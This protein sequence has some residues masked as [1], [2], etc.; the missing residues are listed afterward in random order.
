MSPRTHHILFVTKSLEPSNHFS[1]ITQ[2][3]G[4]LCCSLL[5]GKLLY[6]LITALCQQIILWLTS[7]ISTVTDHK[8][9]IWK[10][11]KLTSSYYLYSP[12]QSSA[13]DSLSTVKQSN[14]QI[15]LA[16][17]EVFVSHSAQLCQKS[18]FT[19]EAIDYWRPMG[20]Q[21]YITTLRCLVVQSESKS[22]QTPRSLNAQKLANLKPLQSLS[23]WTPKRMTAMSMSK[24]KV[25]WP[26]LH[27]LL[28]PIPS[29]FLSCFLRLR[30]FY[31]TPVLIDI[32]LANIESC[33]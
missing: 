11:V 8:N 21:I 18:R 26:A 15:M 1:T 4:S 24:R 6:L 7:I 12:W 20:R 32:N 30:V 25:R 33:W 31:F 13:L 10:T 29:C 5:L 23:K 2:D 22:I 19:R 9:E 17:H 16:H 28:G 14:F 27:S 3:S